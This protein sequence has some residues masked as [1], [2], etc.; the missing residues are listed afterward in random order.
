[1]QT[2]LYAMA[3]RPP[4]FS[5]LPRSLKVTKVLILQHNSTSATNRDISVGMS[6]V[7]L[8]LPTGV[9]VEKVPLEP[10][11]WENLIPVNDLL[12]GAY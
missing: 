3:I 4:F 10:Q 5:G 8:S 6:S 7:V 11:F 12:T 9:K 1:M 2:V